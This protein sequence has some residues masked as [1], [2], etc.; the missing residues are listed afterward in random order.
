MWYCIFN[1]TNDVLCLNANEYL[2]QYFI[3]SKNLEKK[4]NDNK[5][6]QEPTSK[7]YRALKELS[8]NTFNKDYKNNEEVKTLKSLINKN[9]NDINSLD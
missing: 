6:S 1:I 9:E 8:T 2:I 5:I 3:D 7:F 4:K